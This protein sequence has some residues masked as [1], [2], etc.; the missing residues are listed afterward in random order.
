LESIE[1]HGG[2]V[3]DDVN[4]S[5]VVQRIFTKTVSSTEWVTVCFQPRSHRAVDA[6]QIKLL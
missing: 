4:F 5:A 2:S 3:A 6:C 1:H